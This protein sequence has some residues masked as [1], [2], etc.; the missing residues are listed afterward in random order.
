MKTSRGHLTV[1]LAIALS[2]TCAAQAADGVWADAVSGSWSDGSKWQGGVAAGS[3]GTATFKAASGIVSV[4]NDVGTVSLSGITANPDSGNAAEWNILGGTL[5]LVAP[6]LFY[7]PKDRLSVRGTTL[8]GNTDVTITGL[9]KLFLGDDNLYTGRTI[10]SN[11]N[12]RVAKDS[13]LGPVPATLRSD[14]IILDNGGLE[15]DDSD[16]VLE[17]HANR[18]ITVTANGGFLGAGY[19]NAGLAINGPITGVGLLGINFENNAVVLNN[20]ANDYQGGTVVGTTGPGANTDCYPILKLGQSEVLPDGSGMGGLKIGTESSFYNNLPWATLDLNGKTETVNTLVSGPRAQ[21]TSS[22]SGQ[23]RLII[24]SLGEDSDYRGTMTGGAT[25]EKRGGGTLRLTAA[26][27][28]SGTVDLKEGKI[29]AGGPNLTTGSTVLFNG[30]ELNLTAPAG[31]YEFYGVGG[32]AFSLSAPLTY[33]GWRLS[34]EKASGSFGNG[35]QYVYKGRWF[36]PA[37]GTYSFAK[38]FDD[39]GYLAIDGS[40]LINNNSSGTKVVVNDVALSAGWHTVELRVSDVMGAVGPESGFRSGILYDPANSTFSTPEQIASA[41]MFTDDGGTN[42]VADGYDNVLGARLM[43]AT[44]GTLTVDAAAGHAVLAGIL[45]TNAPAGSEPMLTVVNG[46]APLLFGSDGANP[47]VLDAAVSSAGGLVFTNRVWLRRLPS[48]TYSIAS[49]AELALDGP[50]LLGPTA[51]N[52]TGYSVRVV[53]SDSVGG[54]GSVTANSGTAV[55]FDTQRF[56][57]NWLVNDVSTSFACGNNVTLN[58]GA[59]GFSGAG[60]LTYSGTITGSGTVVKNGS[61]D[62]LITGTGSSLSGEFRLDSGRLRPASEAALGGAA[63]RLNGGRLANLDGQDLTLATTPVYAQGGGLEAVGAGRTLTINSAVSGVSPVS[64]WG[65]GTVVLGGTAINDNFQLFVRGGAVDL[66]KTGSSAS[67]AVLN[68]LG[69][70]SGAAVRLTGDNGNQIGGS[71]TLDG[72]ILDLNGHSETIGTLAS[73]L[74]AGSMVTNGGAQA[75]T[76]AVGEGGG[77][78]LFAGRLSDGTSTLTLAKTGSGTLTLAAEALAYTGGTRVEGGTLRIQ[79]EKNMSA[80]Y[81]RFMPTVTRP[82]AA[83]S[84]TGYQIS[85]FQLM[86]DGVPVANPPGT[87]A[88]AE[89]PAGG[90]EMGPMAV[91][92]S[93]GDKWYCNTYGT[94]LTITYGSPVTFNSYRWATA[95][96]AEGRDPIAWTLELGVEV[97]AGV[98]NWYPLD[99]QTGYSPTWA[100]NTWIGTNFMVKTPFNNVIPDNHP[101]SVYTG[102][103]LALAN[104][105]ETLENLAGSGTLLLENNSVVTLT[106]YNGF[107]GTVAGAGTL[108]LKAADGATPSFA[109]RDVG[110]TVRNDGALDTAFLFNSS[111]TNLFGGSLQDGTKTLGVTHAGAG[112]TYFAGTNSTYTGATRIDAGIAAV[113]GGVYAKYIK[114][115]PT[116][117]RGGSDFDCQISEFELMLNGEKVLYP[118]GTSASTSST[119]FS[120]WGEGPAN[121][122]DGNVYTKFYNGIPPVAPLVIAAPSAIFFDGYRWYTA[123][124]ADWR[125]PLSWKIETSL[126]GINWTV[127]DTRSNQPC[128]GDRFALAGTYGIAQLTAEMNVF[129]DLSAT[130]VAAPGTLNVGGTHETVGSLS[131][132]GSVLLT[133]ATLGINAF[134]DSVFSGSI[135]GFGTVVKAGAAEQTLSGALAFSGVIVV[136]NGVLDLSGAVLTGVTN[137]VIKSGATLTGSATVNGNL[138]VTFEEGGMYSGSLAVTGALT[139]TGPVKLTVASGAT[140]PYYNTLFSYAS[141]DMATLGALNAA[142]KPS[143]VPSGHSATVRVT[144]TYTRLIIAPVGMVIFLR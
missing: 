80:K 138:A 123:N 84:G 86:L 13:G 7:T 106:A 133:T 48:G 126:D 111:A 135:T 29:L 137:I 76:L 21:I 28:S 46:G 112:V 95:N 73:T 27:L 124:D 59:A 37:V 25:M 104:L 82:D 62:A 92:G 26:A 121:S 54:D 12:V 44:N 8:S 32:A 88:F 108:V 94:P 143:P 60:T 113:S 119:S 81:L 65:D 100:R 20:P 130:T 120:N 24:G 101:V 109:V 83:H 56:A 68:L 96:D 50:A 34:P 93:L 22:V 66:D 75:A 41:R 57:D 91:D 97:S 136:E 39:G 9:G 16:F 131:G 77:S 127:V 19:S 45:T 31:L 43:L 142:I 103:T 55:W 47:A 141:A 30:G 14:A 116:F 3:G 69:I 36:I 107:T 49:G 128:T 78:S 23:G 10:I 35:L 102:A 64:K 42:L 18:G 90:G 71:V 140:Y 51:L 15:N 98:I 144:D 114:F 139:V 58:G 117:M 6:A 52:L 132:N 85:E 70:E 105:N 134:Q 40:V 87:T 115:T 1:I 122:I 129:S 11:G 110:V 38:A 63:V 53:R 33:G 79:L 2:V 61:G 17:T 4:N 99:A 5:E 74:T 118:A 67:Y 125:D 89:V 72:G